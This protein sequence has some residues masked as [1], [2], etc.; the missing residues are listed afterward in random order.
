MSLLNNQIILG[1]IVSLPITSY[2]TSHSDAVGASDCM[3][4]HLGIAYLRQSH[5]SF[6]AALIKIMCG[7]IRQS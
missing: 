2:Y 3:C 5:Y 4:V 6:S 7:I 1:Y